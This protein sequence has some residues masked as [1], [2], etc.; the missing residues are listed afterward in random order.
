[1]KKIE[2]TKIEN[3]AAQG[4]LGKAR[5]I[6]RKIDKNSLRGPQA[7]LEYLVLCRRLGEFELV[8]KVVEKQPFPKR[9]MVL[10]RAI[11]LGELGLVEQSLD[12]LTGLPPLNSS[13]Y[14]LAYFYHLGTISSLRHQYDRSYQA[15]LK[16]R[17]L[18]LATNSPREGVAWLNMLGSKI[19]AGDQSAEMNKELEE[20]LTQH[21]NHP[22]LRQGGLYFFSL[23]RQNCQDTGGAVE[24]IEAAYELGV[25]HKFR[26]NLLLDLTDFE[27]RTFHSHWH[28]VRRTQLKKQVYSQNHVIYLDQFE[29]IMGKYQTQ[30]GKANLGHR[31][32]AKIIFGQRPNHHMKRAAK[33]FP[34]DPEHFWQLQST[35]C[36]RISRQSLLR[37]GLRKFDLPAFKNEKKIINIAQ[38]PGLL[39]D[40]TLALARRFSYGMTV[41]ELWQEVWGT[42]FSIYSSPLSL[43][44]ALHRW[45]NSKF[46]EFADLLCH[47]KRLFLKIKKGSSLITPE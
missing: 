44:Q 18:A 23:Y 17:Q 47:G 22:I 41:G 19:Y 34:Q 2:K 7:L 14:Q 38:E 36:E 13:E 21:Q 40:L 42:A 8:L 24:Y 5:L 20:F 28:N 37:Q 35:G 4:Q 11:A 30:R 29:F 43:R 6:L 27:L 39:G 12:L 16:M 15:F 46:K 10:E 31:Y 3:L 1:M 32:L 33:I 25:Q 9:E 45:R 26:E